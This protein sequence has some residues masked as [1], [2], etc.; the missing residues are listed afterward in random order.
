M[1]KFDGVLIASDFDNTM[2]Y[3]EGALRSGT[4]IPPLSAEN[5]A[6][7]LYFMEEGG[8]FSVVTGRSLP[9]FDQ[10]RGDIPMNGPAVLFNG[11]A[12]YDFAQSKYLYT[13]FL[14]ETIRSHVTE[15]L[16]A[17]G[18]LTFKIYHDD[19]SM[20]V[21]NPNDLSAQRQ[22]LT[23]H[24]AVVLPSIFQAPSPILK[25]AFEEE[26]EVQQRILDFLAT[27]PWRS[28][29][30]VVSS[31]NYLLEVT[32]H[33]ADKGGMVQKLTELLHI[34]PRHVYAVGDHANDI[35]M[36]RLARQAFAPANAIEAVRSLPGIRV[37]PHCR[38]NA[39]A[40]MIGALDAMY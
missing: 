27:R 15:I 10:V 23:H 16:D 26:L 8:T 30:E 18:P 34:S 11:A 28:G 4:P 6:A 9:S 20:Y 13:A 36:L 21:V 7:I 17:L 37:L 22:H 1:G 3:T 12:I 29:Y 24:P 5:R 25:V 35:P 38:D 39:I 40:A 14:P 19:N 32:V 2:S 31:S 33:G